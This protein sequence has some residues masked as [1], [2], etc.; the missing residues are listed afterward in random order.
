ME[1]LGFHSLLRW[2]MIVLPNYHC[3]TIHFS[4]K[5]W[6]NVLF[7]LGSEGVKSKALSVGRKKKR[8]IVGLVSAKQQRKSDWP[9]VVPKPSRGTPRRDLKSRH[10]FCIRLLCAIGRPDP[11]LFFYLPG[12]AVSVWVCECAQLM[13]HVF[14]YADTGKGVLYTS[15]ADG[16]VYSVSLKDHVVCKHVT[17]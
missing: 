16:V 5:V 6:E 10:V 17:T 9:K 3:I 14:F 2:K 13:L 7:E 8:S 12:S 1:N 4:I 11:I 15:D